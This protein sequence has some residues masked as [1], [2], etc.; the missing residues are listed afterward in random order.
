MSELLN[1]NFQK[2]FTENWKTDTQ[3]IHEIEVTKEMVLKLLKK[4]E[5]R[6]AIGPNGVSGHVLKE[7]SDQLSG[8]ITDIIKCSLNTGR[9]PK[10]WKRADIIPL[11]KS[12]NKQKPLNYSPVSLTSILCKLCERIIKEQWVKYL[13]MN[14]VLTN[15]QSGFREGRSCMTY[16]LSY[17]SSGRHNSGERWM[18]GLHLLR[19]QKSI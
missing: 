12:G 19:S 4:L 11:Y 5:I 10:E 18:G 13:E 2:V 6:K 8:P 9:V 17:Y 7:C 16:L 3:G 1:F 14:D 15:A